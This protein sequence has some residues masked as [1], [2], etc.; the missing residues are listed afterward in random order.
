MN[1][2]RIKYTEVKPGGTHAKQDDAI[3]GTRSDVVAYLSGRDERAHRG[4]GESVTE[5]FEL[6]DSLKA[7]GGRWLADVGIFDVNTQHDRT[8]S[9]KFLDPNLSKASVRPSHECVLASQRHARSPVIFNPSGVW[10]R[11][12]LAMGFISLS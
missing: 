2:Y 4:E 9:T 12:I 11:R 1:S 6:E 10:T 8:G 7:I 3:R 5:H